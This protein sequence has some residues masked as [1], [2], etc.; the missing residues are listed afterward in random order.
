MMFGSPVREAGLSGTLYTPAGPGPHP[1]VLVLAGSGGGTHEQRAALYAAHG[2][3]AL[4]L[5]YFKSPGRPDH[6]D[7]TPLEWNRNDAF[8]V[9][10]WS[11]HSHVNGS[12]EDDAVLY[13]VTDAPTLK[14]LAL[15]REEAKT[16]TDEVIKIAP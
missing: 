12:A 10:A 2:Y 16:R 5:G 7:D 6:I 15:Y 3:A 11:W 14:K 1:A 4:A 9:P 8:C 13:S